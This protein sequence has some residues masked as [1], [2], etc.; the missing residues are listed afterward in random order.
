MVNLVKLFKNGEPFKMSKRAGTFVTLRDVVDEVGR[1]AVRFMMLYRKEL[2]PLD[3][4]FQ[5]VTEQSRD[6]PVF[7]V[8]YGHARCCSVFRKVEQAFAG[9]APASPEVTGANLSRLDHPGEFDLMRRLAEF[10]RLMEG[11]AQAREPHRIAFYL[12]ELASDLHGL[13]N[14]GKDLPQ[15]RFIREDDRELTAARV[16]LVS[17]TANVLATGLKM[18]GVHAPEEMR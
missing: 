13:W 12:Y 4:D 5:K 1:D 18:L 6:N 16:A 3:F 10:P 17:A 15:L 7:Y 8:Q 14:Q 11:A 9:L 2:E